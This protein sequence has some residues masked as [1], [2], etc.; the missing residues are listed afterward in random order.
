MTPQLNAQ[1]VAWRCRRGWHSWRFEFMENV[2]TVDA[3]PYVLWKCRL[4]ERCRRC[5]LLRVTPN[6]N[7]PKVVRS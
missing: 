1:P 6:A 5:H 4:T 2:R 7:L 3:P